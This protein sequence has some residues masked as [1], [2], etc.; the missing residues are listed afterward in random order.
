MLSEL[1]TKWQLLRGRGAIT[2]GSGTLV[3][4]G[5][6]F[7]LHLGGRIDV[8]RQCEIR[9]GAL[10]MTYRGNISIGD[11]CSI[12]PYSVLYGAGGLRVGNDVRIAAHTVIIPS[13]HVFDDLRQTIKK[14]GDSQKGIVIEDDVWIGAHVTVLDG[15]TIRRGCV[16]GAGSVVRSE[17]EPYGVYVGAPARLVRVRGEKETRGTE[18]D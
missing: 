1:S 2:L 6:V 17:T 18:R 14:Q 4:F 9:R 13:Q 16:I 12:N 5:A 7:D 10:L 8:G 15:V 11:R 3:Q